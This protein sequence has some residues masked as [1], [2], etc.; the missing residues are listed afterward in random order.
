MPPA[1]AL[2]EPPAPCDVDPELPVGDPDEPCA[3]LPEGIPEV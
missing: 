3:P 1:P 2:V